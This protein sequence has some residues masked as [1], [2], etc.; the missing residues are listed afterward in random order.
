MPYIF[1]RSSEE[2]QRK[3]HKHGIYWSTYVDYASYNVPEHVLSGPDW[4]RIILNTFQKNVA[5]TKIPGKKFPNIASEN[6][7]IEHKTEKITFF[8]KKIMDKIY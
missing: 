4:F 7:G 2:N 8:K 3:K 5:D 1:C 6:Q